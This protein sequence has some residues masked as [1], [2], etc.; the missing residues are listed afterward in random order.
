[1]PVGKVSFSIQRT[2][3][4]MDLGVSVCCD[5]GSYHLNVLYDLIIKSQ[6]MFSLKNI[7]VSFELSR[8]DGSDDESQHMF[9]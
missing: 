4:V 9:S 2:N 7:S 8:Q 1:M 5:W 3:I 6:H